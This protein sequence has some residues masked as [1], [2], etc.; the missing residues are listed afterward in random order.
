MIMIDVEVPLLGQVYDF[1]LNE[2]KETGKL[3]QEMVGLIAQKEQKVVV[4]EDDLLLY[5][6]RSERILQKELTLKEQGIRNGDRLV[7]F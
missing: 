4:M 6:Y 7:L 2:E 3:I 5:S 1:E